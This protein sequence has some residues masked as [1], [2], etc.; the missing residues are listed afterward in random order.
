MIN[1]PGDMVWNIQ[2]LHDVAVTQDQQYTLCFDAKA[3]GNRT[4]LFDIDQGPEEV[5][6][7]GPLTSVG[8]EVRTVP[9]TTS[10]QSFKQT[11]NATATDLAAR[12]AFNLGLS[13]IDVQL[14]NIGL[15]E[16]AACG[17]ND[18]GQSSSS[19][20]ASSASSAGNATIFKVGDTVEAELFNPNA[21]SNVVKIFEATAGPETYLGGFD[22]GASICLDNIDLTGV[23]SIDMT[24]A[25]NGG[26]IVENEDVRGNG[27]FAIM[28]GGGDYLKNTILAEKITTTTNGWENFETVNVGL[29]K[30]MNG[31]TQLCFLGLDSFGIFNLDKFTLSEAAGTNDSLGVPSGPAVAPISVRGNQIFFGDKVDSI[32]GNSFFWSTR[33]FKADRYY[34]D[35]VVSWLKQDWGSQLV[36]AALTVDDT[37]DGS[38]T[39]FNELGGYITEP[40]FNKSVVR[41]VAHSAIKN[42]MY[43]IIDWHA[44]KAE[45]HE[46]EAI[47]FFKAMATEYGQFNN[48]IYEIYNEPINTPWPTIKGYAERVIAEIRKI[49]PDNLIIVGTRFFSQEVEEAA[50]NP[51]LE[52]GT[53]QLAKNVAYTLHFYAGTHRNSLRQK[54]Q[55]ALDKG[56]ALFV[57]EWGTTPASGFGEPDLA[58]TALWMDFLKQNNISHANWAINGVADDRGTLQGS[59]ANKEGSSFE[60]NWSE[61]DLTTSGKA[62][63]DIIKNW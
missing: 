17:G 60:G 24:I 57:T 13:D 2:V 16:G 28:A 23:K 30:T 46:A 27:R 12:L 54:A 47:E 26:D 56:I 1:Q 45:D 6:G 8:T 41:T 4:I 48:V 52:P 43:V 5:G 42:G 62:V 59:S 53:N 63:R 40:Y 31:V 55:R 32:A 3:D 49:D 29:D 44:H 37:K 38:L 14:D 7:Y 11:F 33:I 22:L 61:S 39:P 19:S 58:E 51:I 15:Y 9:L 36:R 25:R 50:D 34:T 10:Y 20:V 21:S 35:G 18:S